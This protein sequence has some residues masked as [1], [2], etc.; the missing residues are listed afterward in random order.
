VLLTPKFHAELAGEG[1][2]YCWAQ[3]KSYYRRVPVSRKRGRDNF[4]LLVQECTSCPV[5]VLDTASVGK[6]ASRSRAYI[7]TYFHIEQT[8]QRILDPASSI[9]VFPKQELV[10]EEI[11]RVMKNFKG[12]RCALDFDGGFVNAQ[13]KEAMKEEATKER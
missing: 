2:E 10:Y 9:T 12:H 11:E 4:K 13:L 5:N 3:A 1:I 6:C 7:W 8:R